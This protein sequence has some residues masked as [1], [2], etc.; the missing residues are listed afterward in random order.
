M[1]SLHD[2][3]R[4]LKLLKVV[5]FE[6]LVSKSAWQRC[7]WS[8]ISL[9]RLSRSNAPLTGEGYFDGSSLQDCDVFNISSIAALCGFL[10]V[11]HFRDVVLADSDCP[12]H[13]RKLALSDDEELRRNGYIYATHTT[14]AMAGGKMWHLQQRAA[15]Q[16]RIFGGKLVVSSAAAM[17]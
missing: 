5:E 17:G 7:P 12:I 13:F 11:A 10:N 1:R 8:G 3:G 2:G 15:A 16:A 9:V 4:N 6:V 14:S